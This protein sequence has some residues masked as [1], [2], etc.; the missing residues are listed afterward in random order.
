[1]YL[2]P[3]KASGQQREEVGQHIQRSPWE[4]ASRFLLHPPTL[5]CDTRAHTLPPGTLW[6]SR[7][8]DDAREYVPRPQHMCTPGTPQ[9]HVTAWGLPGQP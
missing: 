5:L 2:L 6:R 9:H 1:M 8:G 3:K 4:D 7:D